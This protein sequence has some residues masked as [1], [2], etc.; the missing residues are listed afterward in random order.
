MFWPLGC[1]AVANSSL[2]QPPHSASQTRLPHTPPAALAAAIRYPDGASYAALCVRDIADHSPELRARLSETPGLVGAL[3]AAMA[4]GGDGGVSAARALRKLAG[5]GNA[6]V[7]EAVRAAD[8]L[9]PAVISALQDSRSAAYAAE[10][11]ASAMGQ[12]EV[13]RAVEGMLA[14]LGSGNDDEALAVAT[15]LRSLVSAGPEMRAW[16]AGTPGAIAALVAALRGPGAGAAKAASTLRELGQDSDAARLAIL[17]TPGALAGLIEAIAS[18]GAAAPAAAGTVSWL[19]LAG[20]NAP[21]RVAQAPGAVAALVEGAGRAMR[22]PEAGAC[23]YNAVYAIHK[24]LKHGGAEVA[25]TLAAHEGLMPALF[26]ALD[27]EEAASAAAK[28]LAAITRAVGAAADGAAAALVRRLAEGGEGAAAATATWLLKLAEADDKEMS[29][30]IIAAPGVISAL[31]DALASDPAAPTAG[32][33]VKVIF[34]L[35]EDKSARTALAE[36]PGLVAGI[37]AAALGGGVRADRALSVLCRLAGGGASAARRIYDAPGTLAALV[38]AASRNSDA[39]SADEED[40]DPYADRESGGAE[41]QHNAILALS[42]LMSSGEP[43]VAGGV[44][45]ADGV[46]AA[47]VAT[48]D[49]PVN[50]RI[51][52]SALQ[53]AAASGLGGAAAGA[54]ASGLS[55]GGAAAVAAARRVRKLAQTSANIAEQIATPGVLTGLAG[56]LQSPAAG[57]QSAAA[58]T[59]HTLAERGGAGARLAVADSC[60]V[61]QALAVAVARGEAAVPGQASSTLVLVG[62]TTPG[63]AARL[64][65]APGAVAALA[66]TG[67][68]GRQQRRCRSE[69]AD[70]NGK[71]LRRSRVGRHCTVQWLGR[72]LDCFDSVRAHAQRGPAGAAGSAAQRRPRR[73]RCRAPGSTAGGRRPRRSAGGR[74]ARMPGGDAQGFARRSGRRARRGCGACGAAH[75]PGPCK[76]QGCRGVAAA[77]RRRRP[78]GVPCGRE[79]AGRVGRPRDSCAS[80]GRRR[81]GGLHVC[82]TTSARRRP[83]HSKA[84]RR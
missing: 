36:V 25:R 57:A 53:A 80:A 11:L 3:V 21:E 75:S 1:A 19:A 48:L 71:E 54:L 60:G 40:E 64:A 29:A 73:S 44:A 20:P 81:Q 63:A 22:T 26:S 31:A 65:E 17:D 79:R 52:A 33:A 78:R 82:G 18:G 5:G 34:S 70:R 32:T 50:S 30:W 59:L 43:S 83:F 13:E 67:P 23:V 37:A 12:S 66:S 16:V 6:A 62:G 42:R 61:L 47:L 14:R 46:M 77:D 56:L 39:G 69:G 41:S 35:A 4:G 55:E 76:H 28:A 8:G 51:A 7:V 38:A 74:G 49:Q 15:A 27:S 84:Y 10:I 68:A 9:L 2:A 45:A 24:L 72:Q 58:A